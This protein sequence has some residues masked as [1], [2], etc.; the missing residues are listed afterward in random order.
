[1]N[2]HRWLAKALRLRVGIGDENVPLHAD[3]RAAGKFRFGL[4][5]PAAFLQRRFI[6]IDIGLRGRHWFPA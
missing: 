2:V 5:R 4:S 1:M 6:S 3:R